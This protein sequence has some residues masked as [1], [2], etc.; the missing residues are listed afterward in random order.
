[1]FQPLDLSNL[2]QDIVINDIQPIQTTMQITNTSSTTSTPTYIEEKTDTGFFSGIN[3]KDLLN[4][5]VKTMELQKDMQVSKDN[6]E[7]V[8]Q[9][10]QINRDQMNLTPTKKTDTGTIVLISVLSA[11]AIGTILYFI[12]KKKK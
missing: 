10:V 8:K 2:K 3:L 1:V 11:V 5:G 12:L 6:T 4:T 7:A 9:A